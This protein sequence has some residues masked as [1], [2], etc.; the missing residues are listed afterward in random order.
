VSQFKPQKS[1]LTVFWALAQ[2]PM[3]TVLL[4]G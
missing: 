3:Q 4:F 1:P 2:A